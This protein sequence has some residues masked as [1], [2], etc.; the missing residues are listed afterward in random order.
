M[1]MAMPWPPPTHIVS[2]PMASDRKSTRL[3]SSH[4]QTSYAVF[5]LK[6]KML[7][8]GHMDTVFPVGTAEKRPFRIEGENA[9]GPGVV[10][11]K[12]G[13]VMNAFVARAFA[14]VAPDAAPIHI[15]FTGDEFFF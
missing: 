13:I 9:R 8:L 2:R 4:S 15:L 5:C 1:I 6:K 11:M 10:D 7:L 12:A 14:E 3:N